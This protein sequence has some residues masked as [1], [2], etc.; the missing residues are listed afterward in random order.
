MSGSPAKHAAPAHIIS[1]ILCLYVSVHLFRFLCY[2][3]TQILPDSRFPSAVADLDL[4]HHQLLHVVPA[5][6]A[7]LLGIEGV[8]IL[9]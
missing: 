4:M 5:G 9:G 3:S 1:F 8:R 2:G 7:V 6:G